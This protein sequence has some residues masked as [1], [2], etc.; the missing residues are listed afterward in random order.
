MTASKSVQVLSTVTITSCK[1]VSCGKRKGKKPRAT[2]LL[3]GSEDVE[4]DDVVVPG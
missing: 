4:S 2:L 1:Y 3:I